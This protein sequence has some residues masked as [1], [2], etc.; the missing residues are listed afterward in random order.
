MAFEWLSEIVYTSAFS[1]AGYVGLAAIAT[2]A[3]IG[4]HA[5]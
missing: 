2:L 4:L 1:A 5:I 3:I